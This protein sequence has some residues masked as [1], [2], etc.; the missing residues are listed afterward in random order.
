MLKQHFRLVGK[1]FLRGLA[2]EKMSTVDIRVS[3]NLLN[4]IVPHWNIEIGCY[5]GS[6]NEAESL[7]RELASKMS[8]PALVTLVGPPNISAI[9]EADAQTT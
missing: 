1:R 6:K 3:R 9:S 2:I 7:I 4:Q 8:I 5:A